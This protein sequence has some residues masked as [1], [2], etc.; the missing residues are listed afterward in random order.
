MFYFSYTLMVKKMNLFLK[1]FIIGIAKI[2]PGVSGAMI[3]VMFGIYDR[4]INS[5]TN[6]FDDK[7]ENFKFL[8][9]VGSGIFL[10]IVSCSGLIR[11]FINNYYLVTMMLFIGL[12]VGGTYNYS[13]NIDYSFKNIIIIILVI[14]LV[15]GISVFK[16]DGN[17]IID[18]SF[19]DYLMFFIG[20]VI[21]IF[22][23]IV[24]GI[25]GTA[26]FMLIGMYDNILMLFSNV[27][28]FSYVIDNIMIYISYGL[29]MMISF[30]IFSIGINYLL[31]KYR[32]LFDTIILGLS[33]SS[34]ILLIIMA[35]SKNFRLVDLVVGIILFIVG[36]I[37][38]YLFDR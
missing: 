3:A 7:K 6:F 1:G 21:E 33:I 9:I 23:S 25:S 4:L 24:P 34:I 27:L 18:G 37:V 10:S 2:I 5:I 13:R 38:S 14:L 19:N 8:L 12:I 20:G 36:V 11:Y 16:I 17:Y 29:G 26:L 31:K 30:I 35:F 22:S 15:V 28:N 32:R